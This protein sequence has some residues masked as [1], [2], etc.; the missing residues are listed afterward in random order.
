MAREALVE[1][2]ASAEGARTG[3]M[4]EAQGLREQLEGAREDAAGARQALANRER[5]DAAAY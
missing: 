1:M 3:L 4:D 5:W 2:A